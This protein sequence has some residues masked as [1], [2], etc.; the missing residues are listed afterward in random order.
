MIGAG[1]VAFLPR[2]QHSRG[3]GGV[4]GWGVFEHRAASGEGHGHAAL[5]CC[6]VMR[7]TKQSKGGGAGGGGGGGTKVGV[8][9]VAPPANVRNCAFLH[10]ST[11]C[12]DTCSRQLRGRFR[13]CDRS[14]ELAL[15]FHA[16]VLSD[17]LICA[18]C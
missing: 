10:T 15:H 6:A 8:A 4:G 12:M 3:K 18:T 2:R 16:L 11:I 9:E 14:L 7:R 17:N 1:G 5:P 13:L